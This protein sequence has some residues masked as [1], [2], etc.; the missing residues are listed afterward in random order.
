MAAAPILID[1]LTDEGLRCPNCGS[2]ALKFL[3]QGVETLHGRTVV[4]SHKGI[5][6]RCGHSVDALNLDFFKKNWR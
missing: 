4:D 3:R 5:C 6:Q 2:F 1:N